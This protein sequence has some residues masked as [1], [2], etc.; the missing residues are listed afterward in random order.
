[1]NA[2]N[3]KI[4]QAFLLIKK[5]K[6]SLDNYYYLSKKNDLNEVAHNLY[7]CLRKIK[8]KGYKSIVVEKISKRGLGKAINDRISRA[9][10]F[11][12]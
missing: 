10:Q 6:K 2:K 7:S 11:K 3:A 12:K 8:K 1:M 9:S 5:R 4:D